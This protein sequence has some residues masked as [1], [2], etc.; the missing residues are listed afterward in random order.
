MDSLWKH[1]GRIKVTQVSYLLQA[2]KAGMKLKMMNKN[3]EKNQV[4]H[5]KLCRTGEYNR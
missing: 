3:A 4:M 5:G 1:H 2:W